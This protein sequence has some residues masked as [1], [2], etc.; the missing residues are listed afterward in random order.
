LFE[1]CCGLLEGIGVKPTHESYVLCRPRGGL[2]DTLCQIERCW[3]YTENTGRTLLVDACRSAFFPQLSE[4]FVPRVATEA[5][6]FDPPAHVLRHLDSLSCFPRHLRG[7][8]SG[9]RTLG[10]ADDGQEDSRSAGRLTFG[11]RRRYREEVLVHESA[12]G[13]LKS[14][15]FLER[16][17]LQ[18]AVR[19]AVLDR[20][21]PLPR[22]YQAVHVRNTDVRTNTERLFKRIAPHVRDRTLLVC[23]DDA[24]VIDQARDFFSSSRIVVVSD[25]PHTDGVPLHLG[26][27]KS[28]EAVRRKHAVDAIV[29]LLALGGADTVFHATDSSY[30]RGNK[31]VKKV[32]GFSRLAAHLSRNKHVIDSLLQ[33]DEGREPT[34]QWRSRMLYH[35]MRHR[36]LSVAMRYRR[37]A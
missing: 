24:R 30:R 33:Q 36:V 26:N 31:E 6:L 35:R 7:R 17:V 18:A 8:I 15:H 21:A 27:A 10:V 32:S 1:N 28:T 3:L 14:C 25:I 19:A 13:G 4:F 5:I 12:G 11:F 37:C 20:L 16:V 29:D 2:N 23:S 22:E 9:S 34:L